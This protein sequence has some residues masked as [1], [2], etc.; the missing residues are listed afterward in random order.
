MERITCKLPEPVA[1]E[2]IDLGL[3]QPILIDRGPG[4]D[5]FLQVLGTTADFVIILTGKDV[6]TEMVRSLFRTRRAEPK[7]DQKIEIT[8]GDDFHFWWRIPEDASLDGAAIT[9]IVDAVMRQLP[10]GPGS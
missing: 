2:L 7:A 6:I 5:I 1:A 10:G 8:I 4:L 9:E 3:A